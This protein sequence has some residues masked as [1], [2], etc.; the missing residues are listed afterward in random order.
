MSRIVKAVDSSDSKSA[1]NKRF[2][3]FLDTEYG[4]PDYH[5]DGLFVTWSG[6]GFACD[7]GAESP[8]EMTDDGNEIKDGLF[9]VPLH[10]HDHSGR[11]YMLE[12]DNDRFDTLYF[13]S[14][15]WTSRER[16]NEWCGDKTWD[17]GNKEFR[18]ELMSLARERVK[19]LNLLEGGSQYGFVYEKKVNFVKTF[20]DPSIPEERGHEWVQLDCVHGYVTDDVNDFDFCHWDRDA[21]IVSEEQTF[22]GQEVK[23]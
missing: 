4:C 1:S 17:L 3:I 12:S 14:W 2:R 13:A 20:D 9:A 16:Y 15:L 19:Y 10:C 5:Q 6:C 21:D 23:E 11:H 22:I 7:D 8:L 18:E